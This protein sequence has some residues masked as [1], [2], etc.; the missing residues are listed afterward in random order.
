MC[1]FLS[2]CSKN[3]I[4][5]EDIINYTELS[6]LIKHRGP[7]DF[8]KFESDKYVS[9]FYRLTIRDYS[10][11]SSQPIKS[12][13]GRY[14]ISFNGEI[15]SINNIF[16][17]NIKDY[18]SDTLA[19]SNLLTKFGIGALNNI[20]GMFAILVFDKFKN[21]VYIY[22][23]PFGI[24]P[25]F[26]TFD[27]QKLIICSEQKPLIKNRELTLN[28]EIVSDILK[29]EYLLIKNQLFIMKLNSSLRE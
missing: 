14:I 19:I 8:N 6:N 26:Y 3:Q 11:I 7:D 2:I 12:E 27:D 1:G 18:K 23:D 5:K 20:R 29:W 21:L 22:R 24:K 25:L 15:Y 4:K 9:L 17:H 13:C 28:K 10:F 16:G